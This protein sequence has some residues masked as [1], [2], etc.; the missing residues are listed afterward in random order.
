MGHKITIETNFPTAEF[1]AA[2]FDRV[3]GIYRIYHKTYISTASL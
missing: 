3:F 1:L 2:T